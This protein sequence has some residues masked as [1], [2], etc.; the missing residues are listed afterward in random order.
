MAAYLQMGHDSENL[1]GVSGLEN[2]T[3]L[4]LSPVNR[5]ET[6]LKKNVGVF[7][8]K[9][10]FDIVLD[11]QLYFPQQERGSLPTHSYFPRDLDT[12]D[13]S[14]SRWWNDL[15]KNL[16]AY[17]VDKAVDAVCS[18][19]I[20]SKK[21]TPDYCTHCAETF[22]KLVE[23]LH[24]TSVRPVM[25]IC[26]SLSELA[27]PDDA[28]RIA[29]IVTSRNPQWSYLVVDVDLE[30]RREINESANLCSLMLLVSALEKA[31]CHTIVSHSSSDVILMKAAGASHAASGKFF[32]LRRF[33]RSRFL[34]EKEGGGG[35]LPIGLSKVSWLFCVKLTL[36]DCAALGWSISSRMEIQIICLR[37]KSLNN[38]RMKPGS[39]G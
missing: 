36:R 3:G 21:W 26:V 17:A 9:G 32:N 29:S 7:R 10:A 19:A 11:P 4:I 20:V 35:Q 38:L 1:I 27:E 28:L 12:A 22:A 39:H 37:R 5:T 33:T 8:E 30:P 2:F 34:E 16:A 31:G 18:P 23:T 13:M 6:E 24:G 14:S 15:V 25:T